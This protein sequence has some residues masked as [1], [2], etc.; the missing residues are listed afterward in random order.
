VNGEAKPNGGSR[1]SSRRL[2][3]KKAASAGGGSGVNSANSSTSSLPRS[4]ADF[5][6]AKNASTDTVNNVF[7]KQRQQQQQQQQHQKPQAPAT[8][9]PAPSTP[10]RQKDALLA[11][12]TS[13]AQSP[14]VDIARVKSAQLSN[15]SFHIEYFF[16][17][18]LQ[19]HEIII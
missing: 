9:R 3:S 13:V 17:H 14:V 18:S 2:R 10:A 15:V 1:T 4:E 11:S 5:A 19:K 7:Q 12:S 16:T 6:T 8:D